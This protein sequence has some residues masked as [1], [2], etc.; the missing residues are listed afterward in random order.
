M[1]QLRAIPAPARE[2]VQAA[3]SS[4]FGAKQLR[5][6]QPIE[7]GAS[8]STFRI[9]MDDRAYLLRV[10]TARDV[11]RNPHRSYACMQAAAAAGIAPPVLHMDPVTGVSIV[12]YLP[13]RPL[14]EHPGG[15]AGIVR[16]LA[17]LIARLQATPVFP[18]LADYQTILARSLEL[19][20]GSE[21]FS[22]GVL[23]PHVEAF[24]RIRQVFPWTASPPVS[25]HNDLN[26]GNVLFDGTRIW[27]VDWELAFRNDPWV[28]LAI[29]AE[30]FA[31]TPE[32]ESLLVGSWLGRAP[33]RAERARLLLMRLL[34]RLYYGCL[35]LSN[36]IGKHPRETALPEV[37]L[38]EFRA[39][40]MRERTS[41][42]RSKDLHAG[43]LA[44]LAAF[45]AG[46]GEPS[47]EEALATVVHC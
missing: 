37:S 18:P 47:F 32:L 39:A 11:F 31:D 10:E 3:L 16:E 28:D 35:M 23:D 7:G 40:L 12:D 6:L 36:S 21:L 15:P 24:E 44:Y 46:A 8:A 17:G 41:R 26:P 22:L 25:A 14:L 13:E 29:A 38:A 20:R 27:L 43:G 34:T 45:L 4:A 2:P 5:S 30:F 33:E 1:E 19:V 42:P 9:A